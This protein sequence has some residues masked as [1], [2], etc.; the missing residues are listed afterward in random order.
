VVASGRPSPNTACRLP[1]VTGGRGKLLGS[2]AK[3]RREVSHA[4]GRF[5]KVGGEGEE[6]SERADL[7][8]GVARVTFQRV[9]NIDHNGDESWWQTASYAHTLISG[10]L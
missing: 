8:H 7:L 6:M 5:A 3:G 2:Q 9:S 1:E 10:G 4:V